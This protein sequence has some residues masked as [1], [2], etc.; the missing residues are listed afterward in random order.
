MSAG[1]GEAR[2]P[3]PHRP[4]VTRPTA[5]RGPRRV[6]GPTRKPPQRTARAQ[7]ATVPPPGLPGLPNVSGK[8]LEALR[9]LPDAKWLDR[10]LRGQAWVAVIGVALIG[11][12][13]MQVSLLKLNAGIGQS[14]EKTSV[15]E[16]QNADLRASVSQLSSEERIQQE[17]LDMG[18]VMPP[19]GDVRYVTA[20]PE[21]DPGK[22]VRIM[23]APAPAAEDT[24]ATTATTVATD[25]AATTTSDP[26]AATT[27]TDPA[28]ATTTTDPA[29]TTTT[30]PAATATAAPA[31]QTTTTP[32]TTTP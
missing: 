26:A 15:L 14:V 5:P 3:Q 29:A 25:P 16:R 24:T 9:R 19:A 32:Q 6:S 30:D 27:T 4:R 10:M 8:L 2:V 21:E 12:V 20:R 22:A 31:T 1:V 28:A 18:L 23:H 13:A 11:I 7:A 17:A